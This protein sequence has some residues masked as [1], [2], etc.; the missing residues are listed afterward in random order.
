MWSTICI[1]L[2]RREKRVPSADQLVEPQRGVERVMPRALA[3]AR[4]EIPAFS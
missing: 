1:R 4:C 2:L 3:M